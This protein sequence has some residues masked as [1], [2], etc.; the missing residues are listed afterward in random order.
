MT[1][2][3]KQSSDSDRRS[4][5]GFAEDFRRFFVRGLAAIL[6]TLITLW[7]LVWAWD[8]LWQNIGQHIIILLRQAWYYAGERGWVTP[9]PA[10]Y[11]LYQLNEDNIGTRVLGVFLSVVLIYFIGVFVGNLIGK[12]FW[13]LIERAVLRIPLVRAIYPAVKQVTDFVLADRSR[14]FQSSR[15]VAVQPHE[16]NIWSIGLITSVGNWKLGEDDPEEM[17]TVFIPST[18]TSFSGYVLVVPRKNVIELPMTVEEALRLLVTGGVISPG[19]LTKQGRELP[20]DAME[21]PKTE[22]LTPQSLRNSA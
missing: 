22:P 14:Q 2:Q 19:E 17:V 18:P 15:V 20:A 16:S 4:H 11:I 6:P 13:R 7:L 9:Q 3:D 5:P 8:F 1:A 12:T 10:H 21:G